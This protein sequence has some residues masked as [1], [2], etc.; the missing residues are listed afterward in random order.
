MAD[1]AA[2]VELLAALD[3]IACDRGDAALSVAVRATCDA[4]VEGSRVPRDVLWPVAV[5]CMGQL[6]GE[7][8]TRRPLIDESG[9]EW[10]DAV[11]E[12]AHDMIAEVCR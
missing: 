6:G 5:A 7:L 8:A 12:A 1:P 2:T 3:A 9:N 10:S 11:V 4:V